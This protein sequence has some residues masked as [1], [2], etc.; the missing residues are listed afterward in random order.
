MWE[1]P[2]WELLT[3]SA[4]A[5]AA[6]SLASFSNRA[7]SLVNLSFSLAASFSLL[8]SSPL[9]GPLQQHQKKGCVRT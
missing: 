5:L 9:V 1:G 8:L 7:V 4:A 3:T 6:L 2:G